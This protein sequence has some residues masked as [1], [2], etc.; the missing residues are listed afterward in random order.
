MSEERAAYVALAL[1][2]GIG[3]VRL[4]LLLE[5]F[6]SATGVLR[7]PAALLGA[8]PGL[9]PAAA[10]AIAGR[11]PS[12]GEA[13][14]AAAARLGGRCLL[15]GD[16]E[17]PVLL[18]DLPDGPA[19]LFALGNPE[20]FQRPAVAVVGSRDPTAYGTAV[21]RELAGQA[22]AAG[23]VVASGMARGLDAT[24]HTAALDAGGT[25]IGVLGN[26]FGVIY[27]AANR[28]LYDRV[29]A[30]GLLLSEYPPGDR[31]HAGSF[32]RRNRL[33]SGLA[34]VTVVVEAAPGSGALITA[35]C[36]LEQGR[37][38]M[39]I[40]GNLTSS[41]SWGTNRLIRDGAAP[42][43]DLEDL[44]VH[45]PEIAARR[46]RHQ[47]AERGLRGERAPGLP[48][49]LSEPERRLCEAL[50]DGA[51]PL[52]LAIERARLPAA[53][54]LAAA[55]RLELRG[56]VEQAGGRLFLAA[57]APAAGTGEA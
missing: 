52:D 26:G 43:L 8:V 42:L 25:T 27:P 2:P 46:R 48:G 16:P 5:H 11:R 54:A 31:P 19:L 34:R 29:A 21:C 18:R 13:A 23:L 4:A 37:E 39:A 33:I 30:S 49:D 45:Y 57:A 53:T 10:S 24:A 56:L 12:D 44:L 50:R 22:A 55:S 20:L 41:K 35:Q 9:S 38:V 3:A 6:G 15:P 14:I 47:P 7:A 1:T 36:A 32:P 51:L 40:P 17:F 28:A